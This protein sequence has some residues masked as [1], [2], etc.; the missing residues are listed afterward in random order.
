MQNLGKGCGHTSSK[1]MSAWTI[2]VFRTEVII[3]AALTPRV[4]QQGGNYRSGSL[5][6]HVT[7]GL[8]QFPL[9][10]YGFVGRQM[11]VD[12]ILDLFYKTTQI[13]L[14][15]DRDVEHIEMPFFGIAEDRRGAVIS[16][17]DDE[18]FRR[19]EH[20]EC[21]IIT[22]GVVSGNQLQAT[23]GHSHGRIR[24]D[25][26]SS[27][28][29]SQSHVNRIGLCSQGKGEQKYDKGEESSTAL[30]TSVYGII[31]LAM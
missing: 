5:L 29:A 11:V 14:H 8:Y 4:G 22:A 9:M 15:L 31:Q 19:V 1:R 20:M 23:G 16:W 17:H 18:A 2:R 12:A 21:G 6:Y 26:L 13:L 7:R 30:S 27:D 3:I 10:G 24:V 25:E 28:L